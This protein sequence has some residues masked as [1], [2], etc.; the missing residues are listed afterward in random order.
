MSNHMTTHHDDK[1]FTGN[2]KDRAREQA[3]TLVRRL[4]LKWIAQASEKVAAQ[5]LTLPAVAGAKSVGVYLATP[6][7]VQTG[8]LIKKLL[9]AG[10]TIYVPAWNR[11]TAGYAMCE[12]AAGEPLHQ[13]HLGVYEPLN[14]RW[15]KEYVDVM[16]V[17]MVAFDRFLQRLGH[18]GGHFDRLLSSHI[19]PKVGLAF[20]TQRLAAVPVQPHDVLMN[21]VVSEQRVYDGNT[22][23]AEIINAPADLIAQRG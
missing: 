19:G 22:P 2:P 16:I 18:G 3:R 20:E 17:P 14:P 7:E 4:D 23:W 15:A 11:N 12:Y 10:K 1:Q 8:G 6:H 13:A 21:F 9:A 5:V